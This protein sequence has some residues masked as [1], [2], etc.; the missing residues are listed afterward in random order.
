MGLSKRTVGSCIYLEGTTQKLC[1]SALKHYIQVKQRRINT[2][3]LGSLEPIE[4]FTTIA[5]M[6][7][8]MIARAPSARFNGVNIKEGTLTH[9]FY[10]R[11][12]DTLFWLDRGSLFVE[13]TGYGSSK[14]R[15]FKL[16]AIK[17]LDEANEWM[18]LQCSER[19]DAAL[20]ATVC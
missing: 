14:T 17:V 5:S 1:T 10:T 18:L 12:D 4:T 19:G 9:F 3:K 20:E 7:S 6:Y 8:A 11:Y 13:F 15:R 2:P 16:L